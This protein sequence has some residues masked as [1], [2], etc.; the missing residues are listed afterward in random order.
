MTF[1]ETG[2]ESTV[3]L[4]VMFRNIQD[5]NVSIDGID[6]SRQRRTTLNVMDEDVP[7]AEDVGRIKRLHSLQRT[8][9]VTLDRLIKL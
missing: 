1:A 7:S 9:K 3:D 8:L 2:S 5:G 6:K 4:H